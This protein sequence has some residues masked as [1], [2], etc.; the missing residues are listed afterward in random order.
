MYQML[1]NYWVVSPNNCTVYCQVPHIVRF[2]LRRP[3]ARSVIK[4]MEDLNSAFDSNLPTGVPLQTTEDHLGRLLGREPLDAVDSSEITWKQ[5]RDHAV[6]YDDEALL[7][8]EEVENAEDDVID[9]DDDDA[10]RS[11]SLTP[12]ELSDSTSARDL[13]DN[14][15][16]SSDR[17]GHVISPEDRS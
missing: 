9:A 14:E 8:E 3:V 13:L 4:V 6:D 2:A 1:L 17:E 7:S 16:E 15:N 5:E 12:A 10:T 11:N